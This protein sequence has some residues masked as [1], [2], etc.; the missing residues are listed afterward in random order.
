MIK[1]WKLITDQIEEPYVY[2][3]IE[4]D[5]T[6]VGALSYRKEI[7]QYYVSFNERY[8]EV[9][10]LGSCFTAATRFIDKV[11]NPENWTDNQ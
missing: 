3:L 5:N 7:T 6:I 1:L 2:Y 9:D 8:N 11:I 4:A 10:W